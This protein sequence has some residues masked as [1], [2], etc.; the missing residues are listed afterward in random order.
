MV[1]AE[2]C[3]EVQRGGWKM[4]EGWRMYIVHLLLM[5]MEGSDL[6]AFA[7]GD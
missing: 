6:F 5:A 2:R 7:D 3:R 1:D 4:G